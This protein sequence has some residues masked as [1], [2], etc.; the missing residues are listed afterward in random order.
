MVPGKSMVPL[1]SAST[2]LIMS[3][4][5]DSLGFWPSERITVPSSLVV[6]WPAMQHGQCVVLRDW[7]C[8]AASDDA[9]GSV[10]ASPTPRDVWCEYRANTVR[11][12][13]VARRGGYAI[14]E[15][16]IVLTIA[17]LVLYEVHISSHSTFRWALCRRLGSNNSSCRASRGGTYKQRECL[18]ELGDL[19]LGKRVSLRQ[20]VSIRRQA[21]AGL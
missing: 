13:P 16:E 7:L 9:E 14:S 4:S 17:V 18:L 5:S 15:G 2:S 12:L 21:R 20:L 8:D 19:L 11:G 10:G 1:L 6:I 3:W